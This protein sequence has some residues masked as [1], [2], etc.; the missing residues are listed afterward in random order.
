[1]DRGERV[2]QAGLHVTLCPQNEDSPWG[3]IRVR[4]Q[5]GEQTPLARDR[6]SWSS[7]LPRDQAHS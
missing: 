5:G 3:Q 6:A 4:S 7:S 2:A 1:M